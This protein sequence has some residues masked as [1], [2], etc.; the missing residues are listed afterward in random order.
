MFLFDFLA[1]RLHSKELSMPLYKVVYRCLVFLLLCSLSALSSRCQ[2][3]KAQQVP[4]GSIRSETP[5]VLEDHEQIIAY[6]TTE[7]GWNSELQLRNN[8]VAHELTVT[9]ALRL[10]DGAETSLA[11]VTIKPQEVK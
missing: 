7:T 3:P 1:A 5:I 4:A 6:W 11:P 9:P 2:T 8:L 10:A